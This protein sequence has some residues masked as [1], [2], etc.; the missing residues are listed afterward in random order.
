[1]VYIIGT[2]PDYLPY[3]TELVVKIA[4]GGVFTL[5]LIRMGF[6]KIKKF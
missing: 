4:A 5:V 2:M 1:M 3:L 6:D